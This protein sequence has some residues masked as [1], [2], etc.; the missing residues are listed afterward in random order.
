MS[1]HLG[2][3]RLRSAIRRTTFELPQRL[4]PRAH[5]CH[6]ELW[7]FPGREVPAFVELVVVHELG[8]PARTSP[9]TC[10][11]YSR[12]PRVQASLIATSNESLVDWARSSTTRS[13]PRPSSTGCLSRHDRQHQGRQLPAAGKEEGRL[14]RA[15]AQARRRPRGGGSRG[16]TR[17]TRTSV[18]RGHLTSVFSGQRNPALTRLSPAQL[19]DRPGWPL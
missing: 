6:E 16:V 4:E 11:R 15:Q 10:P 5:L 12:A 8:I 19:A 7:L 17:R 2:R 13:S 1:C 9:A 18:N 3:E 14:A